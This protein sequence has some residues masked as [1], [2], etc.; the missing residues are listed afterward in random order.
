MLTG[1]E[2]HDGIQKLIGMVR[3]ENDWP[4]ARNIVSSNDLY[5]AKEYR[6]NG[7]KENFDAKE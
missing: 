6:Y 7:M 2:Y 4:I 5:L 1:T 3:G